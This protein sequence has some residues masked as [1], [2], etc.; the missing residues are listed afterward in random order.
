MAD[1][2]KQKEIK[3]VP[4]A[5]VTDAV[6][7]E[8]FVETFHNIGLDQHLH[9]RFRDAAGKLKARLASVVARIPTPTKQ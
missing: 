9:N 6:V 8:W 3:Q 4:A 7:E 5:P 1:T 2:E